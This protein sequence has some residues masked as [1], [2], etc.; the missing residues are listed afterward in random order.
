[1]KTTL[2]KAFINDIVNKDYKKA[3]ETL[4]SVVETQLSSRV[5]NAL[6]QKKQT[7]KDK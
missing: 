4:S 5:K 1:M 7:E 6:A 3:N 2:I